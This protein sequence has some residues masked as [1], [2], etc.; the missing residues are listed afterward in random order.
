MK[1]LKNMLLAEQARLEA[2]IAKVQNE[3]QNLPDGRLRVSVDKGYIRYYHCL[4][5]EKAEAYIR[6]G[7]M[8][9]AKGLAQKGYNEKILKL[10][11]KRLEQI[12]MILADYDDREIENCYYE[13]HLAKRRLI[14]PV[15]STWEERVEDWLKDT[16]EGKPFMDGTKEI[17]TEKCERV[18]SKSEKILAD[19]FYHHDIAYKY[20][21]PLMLK[22]FGKIY[23]DFTFLSQ[24]TGQEIYWEHDGM[25]DQA[26]Y[27]RQAIRKIEA[28]EKNGIF[29]GER[30]ILTFETEQTTLNSDLITAQVERYL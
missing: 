24:K 10:A 6:R 15:E 17:Y 28:Y 23:P 16:Y 19:Y 26:D 2:I 20:E 30:L 7:K 27:A 9:L 1:G 18:R 5:S 11:E 21:C 12:C 13:E 4:E 25:M 29:P 22:G 8:E 3:K 14:Q